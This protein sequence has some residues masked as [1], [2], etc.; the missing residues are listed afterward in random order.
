MNRTKIANKKIKALKALLV[1]SISLA[2]LTFGY[3]NS[4]NVVKADT[5]T[6]ED[7]TAFYGK[8]IV[9]AH[10]QDENGNKLAEDQVIDGRAGVAYGTM[11]KAIDGY[12][13]KDWQGPTEGYF[14]NQPK[15]EVTY[16]YTKGNVGVNNE[17]TPVANKQT[18]TD[19]NQPEAP[20]GDK[21]NAQKPSDDKQNNTNAT[22][23]T[24]EKNQTVP[25]A[26]QQGKANVADPNSKTQLPQTGSAKNA[27]LSMILAGVAALSISF[28]GMF[29]IQRKQN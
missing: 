15:D 8:S 28:L 18:G 10:Y 29:G 12:T 11:R 4:A 2:A 3:A 16:I 22:G 26:T 23:K 17:Q 27:S 25:S 9:V 24:P 5:T 7:T 14:H 1:T 21:Q 6:T 19:N 13:L 20:A